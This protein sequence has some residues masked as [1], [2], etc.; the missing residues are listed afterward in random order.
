[1]KDWYEQWMRYSF[2]DFARYG[3]WNEDLLK[4]ITAGWMESVA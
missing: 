2:D 4:T 1:M 3:D